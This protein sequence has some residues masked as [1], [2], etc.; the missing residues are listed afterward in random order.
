MVLVSVE[1][2]VRMRAP[3][4]LTKE[5]I[6]FGEHVGLIAFQALRPEE[7]NLPAQLLALPP[8]EDRVVTGIH[9]VKE[10]CFPKRQQTIWGVQGRFPS[11]WRSPDAA[12][13]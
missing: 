8:V 2:E 6:Q 1:Q 5:P 3:A 4:D 11:S 10:G 12:P 13:N 7:R 9:A